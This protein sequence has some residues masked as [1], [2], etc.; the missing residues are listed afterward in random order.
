MVWAA[1]VYMRIEDLLLERK[2]AL[3]DRWFNRILESYP[4]EVSGFFK[5]E[6]DRFQNPVAYQITHGISGI[7]DALAGGDEPEK[8]RPLLDEIIRIRAVQEIPPSKAVSLFVSLKNLVREEFE[9]E[10]DS[11]TSAEL[12]LFE[13]KLDALTFISFDVYMSFREKLFEIKVKDVKK[14]V[15]GLLRMSGLAVEME[16]TK[17]KDSE[18]KNDEVRGASK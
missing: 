6:R 5:K 14:R 18:G 16:E 4:S 12:S 2:S 8:I 17:F 15:S 9:N 11:I 1:G 13:A 10:R 3:L 7:Y